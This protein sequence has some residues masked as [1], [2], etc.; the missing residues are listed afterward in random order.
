LIA[1]GNYAPGMRLG[2]SELAE[3]FEASRVPVREALKLLSAE[4]IVDHDPNRGFFVARFSSEEAKQYF[5]LRDMIEDELLASIRWPTK[6]ELVEFR[7]RA[8]DLEDL[9]NQ[10]N[11]AEWWNQHQQFHLM[12]FN[13][14][15]LKIMVREAMR[16]WSLTDRYRA[17]VSLPR[18]DSAERR[19]VNKADLIDALEA[20]RMR[21]LLNVRAARRQ[22][23]E[24][25]VLEVLQDRGF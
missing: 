24:Q 17:L 13:L 23:F 21:D 8:Q 20:N 10:G 7:R 11:R 18:R 9:L 16:Y 4:G 12:L 5:R 22:A 3:Q 14:S 1:C 25:A 19:I 2:Q 6:Q 15:P